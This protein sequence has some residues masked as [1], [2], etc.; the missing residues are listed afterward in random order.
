MPID[1][2]NF[3]LKLSGLTDREEIADALYR[4]CYGFDGGNFELFRSGWSSK[5]D[6]WFEIRNEKKVGHEEIN[7]VFHAIAS[8]DSHHL[9]TNVRINI[10]G[11]TAILHANAQNQHFRNNEGL[12]ISE[13]RPNFLGGGVY[14]VHFVKEEGEWKVFGWVYKTLWCQG[15]AE[16][17][18][19]P[20]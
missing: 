12:Q 20:K 11:E 10:K 18:A 1:T 2:S 16:T 4:I 3:P 8:L 15:S 17:F 14:E 6:S 9:I 13:G 5:E 7:K 19:P